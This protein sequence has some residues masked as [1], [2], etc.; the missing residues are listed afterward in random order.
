MICA[1]YS[2]NPKCYHQTLR[3]KISLGSFH[4][5]NL[6]RMK[7]QTFWKRKEVRLVKLINYVFL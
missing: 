3:T 6:S 7:P 2:G 5:T 4:Y 1:I